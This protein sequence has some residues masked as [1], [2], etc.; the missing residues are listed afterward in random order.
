MSALLRRPAA[1]RI[2]AFVAT[3]SVFAS[4]VTVFRREVKL[5]ASAR[6]QATGIHER[7]SAAR[8]TS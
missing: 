2:A 8:S 6:A 3:A 1:A 7:A 4:A 5:T